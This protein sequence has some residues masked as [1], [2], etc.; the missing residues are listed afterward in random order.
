MNNEQS[1]AVL[2]RQADTKGNSIAPTHFFTSALDGGHWSAS[3]PGRAL[4][5]GK[6]P[7]VQI[8]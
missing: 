1:K 8:G 5:T 3:R 7:Q 6:R 4:P 2:T